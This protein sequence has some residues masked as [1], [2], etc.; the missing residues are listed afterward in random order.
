MPATQDSLTL[1]VFTTALKLCLSP[2][3]SSEWG[4]VWEEKRA[5]VKDSGQTGCPLRH[6]ALRGFTQ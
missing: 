1:V 5:A 3:S 4:E 6:P 2:A